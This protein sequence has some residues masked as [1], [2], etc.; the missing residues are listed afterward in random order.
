MYFKVDKRVVR[1]RYNLFLKEL[2][3]KLKNEEKESG[4]EID[5]IEVEMV[6]EELIEK[7]DVVEIE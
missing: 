6:L 3:N 7:E 4:I 2:R 1:D 5:M